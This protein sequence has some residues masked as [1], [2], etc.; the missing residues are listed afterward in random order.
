ML[1]CVCLFGLIVGFGG[2]DL[3]GCFCFVGFD[4]Q[5]LWF[6]TGLLMY[7]CLVI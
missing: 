2:F 4:L 6:G 1:W 5:V 3:V 7:G